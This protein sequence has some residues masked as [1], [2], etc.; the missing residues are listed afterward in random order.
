MPLLYQYSV[1]SCL[2]FATMA[3]LPGRGSS[4]CNKDTQEAKYW[5]RQ[6]KKEFINEIDF[7][8]ANSMPRLLS[9]SNDGDCD[10]ATKFADGVQNELRLVKEYQ[11]QFDTGD[12]NPGTTHLRSVFGFF[13]KSTLLI[14]SIRP[15]HEGTPHLSIQLGVPGCGK[16]TFL[17][18][19]LQDVFN[20][21]YRNI[22]GPEPSLLLASTTNEQCKKLFELVKSESVRDGS[23]A[24]RPIWCVSQEYLRKSKE[25]DEAVTLQNASEKHQWPRKRT[26]ISARTIMQ[27]NGMQDPILT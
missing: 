3:K 19:F 7:N 21:I 26:F 25:A 13:G 9:A 1:F 11:E 17:S 15:R 12:L 18:E 10:F 14:E 5:E 16:S 23:R 22:T 27:L 8:L 6:A 20:G 24:P 4:G 2:S